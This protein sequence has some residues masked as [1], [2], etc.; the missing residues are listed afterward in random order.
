MHTY[1]K[2]STNRRKKP[3]RLKQYLL[4]EEVDRRLRWKKSE[5][6]REERPSLPRGEINENLN[7]I[8]ND[9]EK[10]KHNA[11]AISNT[12]LRRNNTRDEEAKSF[13]RAKRM[14]PIRP[15][16]RSAIVAW[17]AT[18]QPRTNRLKC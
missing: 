12:H 18:T 6:S 14:R 8:K 10:N 2:T 1:A 4:S 3:P 7:I 15:I 5:L 16:G 11:A 17:L 9:Q 13:Q